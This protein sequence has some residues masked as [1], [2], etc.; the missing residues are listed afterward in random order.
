MPNLVEGEGVEPPKPEGQLGYSQRS[1]PMHAP[2][3][4]GK[5]SMELTVSFDLTTCC[6]QDSC[7][8]VELRQ[9][10]QYRGRRSRA[11]PGLNAADSRHR[12]SL[13]RH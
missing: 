6:L 7:S 5:K 9:Q 3:R 10:I 11:Q 13:P 1:S 4:E 8:A 12:E 2:P